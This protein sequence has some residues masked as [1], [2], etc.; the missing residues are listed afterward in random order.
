MREQQNV[1]CLFNIHQRF[2]KHGLMILGIVSL[3][4]REKN[5]RNSWIKIKKNRHEIQINLE[6]FNNLFDI[7]TQLNYPLKIIGLTS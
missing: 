4:E 6:F 7:W 5:E 3:C 1:I 2:N